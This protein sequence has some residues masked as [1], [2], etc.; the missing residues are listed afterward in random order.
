M[1]HVQDENVFLQSLAIHEIKYVSLSL[2]FCCYQNVEVVALI[3]GGWC[4]LGFDPSVRY[5][6][7]LSEDVFSSKVGKSWSISLCPAAGST[8]WQAAGGRSSLRSPLTVCLGTSGATLA[9]GYRELKPRHEH[10]NLLRGACILEELVLKCQ[11]AQSSMNPSYHHLKIQSETE[12]FVI[13]CSFVC[14]MAF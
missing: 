8:D 7:L 2:V 4:K 14:F 5:Q 6:E 1:V 10:G 13:V 3:L 9:S 12:P 11:K